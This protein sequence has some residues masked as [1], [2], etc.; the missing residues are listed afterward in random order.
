IELTPSAE[1]DVCDACGG[2][3]VDWFDGDVHTLAVE[4]EIARRASDPGA[5]PLA[6]GEKPEP[7]TCPRCS[8][9]LSAELHRF[10][11]ARDHEAE[12][13]AGVEVY[14]CSECAGAFVPRGSAHLLLDRVTEGPPMTLWEVV[15][16]WLRRVFQRASRD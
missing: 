16:A 6:L 7:K 13:V 8:Q 10:A 1:V 2:M 4:T 15:V 14:R 5:V 3:W 11:D 12:L 9:M